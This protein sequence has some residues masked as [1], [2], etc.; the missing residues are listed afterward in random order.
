M[1]EIESAPVPQGVDPD[2]HQQLKAALAAYIEANYPDRISSSAPSGIAGRVTELSLADAELSWTYRNAGD[3]NGDG[4]VTIN[5]LTNIGINYQKNTL[6]EDWYEARSADGNGD[7]EV[8]IGD[9]T[10]IGQNYL[11]DVSGYKVLTADSELGP[12]TELADIPLSLSIPGSQPIAFQADLTGMS[13]AGLLFVQP[14]DA[15]NGSGA[16]SKPV[17]AGGGASLQTLPGPADDPVFEH[18]PWILPPLPDYDSIDIDSDRSGLPVSR[19]IITVVPELST[20]VGQMNQLLSQY[21]ASV[22]GSLPP[23]YVMILQLE[24]SGD[25]SKLHAAMDGLAASPQIYLVVEDTLL[26]EDSLD[27]PSSAN[28]PGASSAI[29]NQQVPSPWLWDWPPS[30]TGT[31]VNGNWGM[32]AVR[33]PM[34]WN[35]LGLARRVNDPARVVI[36]DAGFNDAH[37]DGELDN[38]SLRQWEDG[39]K[40]AGLSYSFHGAHIAG[41]IGAPHYNNVGVAGINPLYQWVDADDELWVGWSR[42]ARSRTGDDDF[43]RNES[44][45]YTTLAD[46]FF[47]INEWEDTVVV[48]TSQ[49]YSWDNYNIDTGTSQAAQ[50][51]VRRQGILLRFLLSL[52]PD[53]L[54]CV[55]TGNGSSNS[56]GFTAEQHSVWNSPMTWAGQDPEEVEYVNGQVIGPLE[57]V[58]AVESVTCVVPDTSPTPNAWSYRKSDF[59]NVGGHSSGP[60]TAILSTVGSNMLNGNG[61]PYA[62]YDTFSGTSMSTPMV[63]GLISYLASIDPD[64][65][66]AELK[67]LVTEDVYT[68]VVQLEPGAIMPSGVSDP[69][70][71]VD[72]FAAVIGIDLE[73]GNQ[74]IQR[75]LVDVDDGTRDGNLR[76]RVLDDA[77]YDNPPDPDPDG[78]RTF[79]GRRGD[80][81]TGMKDFRTYRDAWLAQ[82]TATFPLAV[83]LDGS[84]T[85]YKKDYNFDGAISTGGGNGQ[86]VVPSHPTD[87]ATANQFTNVT[88]EGQYSR[89]DFNGDGQVADWTRTSPFNVNAETP[90]SSIGQFDVIST[91]GM[92]RDIDVMAGAGNWHFWDDIWESEVEDNKYYHYVYVDP[93]EE[94][95]E[96]IGG[97]SPKRFLLANRDSIANVDQS[98]KDT[99]D[100]MHSC[101]IHFN[102]DWYY[103][104]L[105]GSNSVDITVTS[106]IDGVVEPF[107]RT[108]TFTPANPWKFVLTMPV[109]S[110]NINISYS[111][112]SGYTGSTDISASLGEDIPFRINHFYDQPDFTTNQSGVQRKLEPRMWKRDYGPGEGFRLSTIFATDGEGGSTNINFS[113][114]YSKEGAWSTPVVVDTLP[115]VEMMAGAD[116]YGYP[117]IIIDDGDGNLQFKTSHDLLNWDNYNKTIDTSADFDEGQLELI[118][119]DDEDDFIVYAKLN[120]TDADIFFSWNEFGTDYNFTVPQSLGP[121]VNPSIVSLPGQDGLFL[122]MFDPAAP[123]IDSAVKLRR[124]DTTA[125]QFMPAIDLPLE[126]MTGDPSGLSVEMAEFAGQPAIALHSDGQLYWLDSDGDS[127]SLHQAGPTNLTG[128]SHW[129]R[130]QVIESGGTPAIALG[131]MIWQAQ[132]INGDNW[133]EPLQFKVPGYSVDPEYIRFQ[134]AAG[135]LMS[136]QFFKQGEDFLVMFGSWI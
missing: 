26:S 85:H 87:V 45:Y 68:R 86:P 7:G 46:V 105:G 110:G 53:V 52:R 98:F 80:N 25:F 97:W 44:M 83:K 49:G 19:T 18:L 76:T 111:T 11:S 134:T 107:S 65:T 125:K 2:I 23:L 124:W 27:N 118:Q 128:L 22:V 39:A 121:G 61:N 58:I 88:P 30:E 12:F 135:G 32:E 47:A 89:Y 64:L 60:G 115:A 130:P 84:V 1:A 122:V 48:N 123:D 131:G 126:T 15:Q 108:A 72:A 38:L 119:N 101:D 81:Q 67:R 28:D 5:D 54:L 103:L 3:Y 95:V 21:G 109:W 75:A 37:P 51:V 100:Y 90:G 16:L 114:I 93:T 133:A 94:G 69:A 40:V 50:D 70:P 57:N 4:Q 78:I 33:A 8:N 43:E 120:P 14:Y 102:L 62:D 112:S 13:L 9:I 31:A 91:P 129:V 117:A 127:F 59:S 55:S 36:M 63:A 77:G 79:D 92:L 17:S 71:M 82:N 136:A 35:L 99:P 24:D 34:A 6:S 56:N 96:S 10:P 73:Q 104:L 132:D 42:R 29:T 116:L 113:S 41:I 20:T 74:D 66:P 106:E